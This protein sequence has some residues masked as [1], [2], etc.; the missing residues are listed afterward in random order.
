MNNLK[1]IFVPRNKLYSSAAFIGF[2]DLFFRVCCS[3]TEGCCLV[4]VL[5]SKPDFHVTDPASEV[6]TVL[7]SK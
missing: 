3:K 7:W 6:N 5:F 4:W 1:F 2:L